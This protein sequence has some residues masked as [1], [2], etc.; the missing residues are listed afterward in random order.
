MRFLI[1]PSPQWGKIIRGIAAFAILLLLFHSLTTGW[2]ELAIVALIAFTLGRVSQRS[3]APQSASV[4]EAPA[5][6]TAA[7]ETAT[8]KPMAR[9]E[10]I[11]ELDAMLLEEITEL[12]FETVDVD[13]LTTRIE[14]GAEERQRSYDPAADLAARREKLARNRS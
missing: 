6:H 8:R 5:S 7:P 3:S 11:A 2:L 1:Q 12:G 13:A 4:P 9:A 10:E 14:R